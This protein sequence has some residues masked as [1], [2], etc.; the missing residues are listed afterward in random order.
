MGIYEK[1]AEDVIKVY[2]LFLNLWCKLKLVEELALVLFINFSI[3]RN[4]MAY[5]SL[6]RL[7]LKCSEKREYAFK[8][9]ANTACFVC[10]HVLYKERPILYVAHDNDGDWQFLCGHTHHTDEHVKIISLREITELDP[11]INDL[12]EMPM[13]VGAERKTVKDK[14]QPFK[15]PD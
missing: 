5:H 13:N 9:S 11:T 12:Y 15:L 6:F 8:E 3:L 10:S 4:K 7:G 2:L 1:L 14:W